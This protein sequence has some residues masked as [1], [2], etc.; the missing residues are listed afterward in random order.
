M[1]CNLFNMLEDIYECD[2]SKKTKHDYDLVLKYLSMKNKLLS[3]MSK[4]KIQ[5]N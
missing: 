3:Y 4:V 2:L 1:Y 5:V